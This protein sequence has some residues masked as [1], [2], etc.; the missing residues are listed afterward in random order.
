MARLSSSG[1]AVVSMGFLMGIGEVWM[2]YL[3]D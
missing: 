3:I 1:E 2:F